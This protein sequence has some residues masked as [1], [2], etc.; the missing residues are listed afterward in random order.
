MTTRR[1]S[2]TNLP[3]QLVDELSLDLYTAT[4]GFGVTL[5]TSSY[6]KKI[7]DMLISCDTDSCCCYCSHAH[8][9]HIFT[10]GAPNYPSVFCFR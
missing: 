2:T 1:R 5:S 9:L 7:I 3:R 10:Y 6:M 4:M 8:R